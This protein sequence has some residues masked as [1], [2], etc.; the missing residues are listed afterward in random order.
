MRIVSW[1]MNHCLRSPDLRQRAWEYLRDELKAD[2]ALVQESV[3]PADVISAYRP[4]DATNPRLDWGSAVVSFRPDIILKARPRVPLA[5]CYTVSIK[6]DQVPDSH[7][8]ASAVA[9]VVDPQGQFYFT[10]VSLYGQWEAIPDGRI[11]ACARLHRMISDLTNILATSSRRPLLLAGDFN[12]TT[13]IA[14]SNQTQAETDGAIAV[15]GRLKAW[16]LADCFELTRSSRPPLDGC[17]CPDPKPCTHVRTLRLRNRQDSR[18]TQLDYAFVSK[19][20][21]P[22]LQRCQ[23]VHTDQAWSLSDHSPVVVDLA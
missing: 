13:Q 7:P 9:D 14:S 1:N 19:N 22:K 23:V 6:G 10:A 20:L 17:T 12:V 21:A 15:F 3:P 8:G 4:I 18:P 11:Y 2:I 5:D 16:G